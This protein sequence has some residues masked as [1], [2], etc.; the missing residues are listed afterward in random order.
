MMVVNALTAQNSA[1]KQR[2]GNPPMGVSTGIAHAPIED[3]Q[4]RPITAGA[5]VIDDVSVTAVP[6]PSTL[7]LFALG[8]GALAALHW[9]KRR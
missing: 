5:F 6:E 8:I 1:A 4:S 2:S 7:T 9:R 3:D